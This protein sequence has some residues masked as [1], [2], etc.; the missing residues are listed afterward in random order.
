MGNALGY[1]RN[2]NECLSLS[3]D[4]QLPVYR[5]HKRRSASAEP[6]AVGTDGSLLRVLLVE[7]VFSGS[8]GA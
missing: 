2:L 6:A 5:E 7:G 4:R 3:A 1:L 8:V